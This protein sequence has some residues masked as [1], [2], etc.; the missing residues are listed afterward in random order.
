MSSTLTQIKRATEM[1]GHVARDQSVQ[2]AP[3]L[4]DEHERL[5]RHMQ[6]RIP[7][8]LEAVVQDILWAQNLVFV[9]PP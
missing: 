9:F 7:D 6:K 4:A 2:I 3:A 5:E 1:V 8:K